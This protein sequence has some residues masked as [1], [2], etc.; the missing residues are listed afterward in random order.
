MLKHRYVN[1]VSAMAKKA[2]KNAKKKAPAKKARKSKK[3]KKGSLLGR[4]VKWLFVLGLWG[5]IALTLMLAWYAQDLPD[6]TQA[7]TFERR[8]SIIIKAADGSVITRYGDMKRT[9][10][11]TSDLPSHLIYAIISTE[12][13]RFYQHYGVDPMGIARAMAVNVQK[14]RL[15]QG[16]STIT[17]QL[18]KNLFLSHERTLKRKI[19][20]AM[21]ALWL[22]HGLTKDEILSAYLNR[23]YLGSGAYGVDAAA[24]LYFGKP[25]SQVN[26]RESAT[27]AGLLKA[28]SRYSPLKNPE[29][30]RTR[31]D[32]V[33]K[34]MV[35][36]G[37]ITQDQ[38]EGMVLI[39]ATPRPQSRSSG[40]TRYYTDWVVDGIDDLIGTPRQDLIVHTTLQPDIQNNVE[41]ALT[42]TLNTYGEER[43][44]SQGAAVILDTNGAVLAMVGGKNYRESQF[45]RITQA[46]RQPGSAFK[47]IL[48]L[49]AL[50]KGWKPDDLILDAPIKKGSY[51]PKN[52][53]HEYLGEITL[54][55]A[56]TRSLNTAA[57]R[58]MKETG[59]GPVIATARRLGIHSKL[60]PDLSL[61]LGSSVVSPLEMSVAY[62]SFANGGHSV[63]P[64]AITRITDDEDNIYYE[65]RRRRGAHRVIEKSHVNDLN[66]MLENVV[67]NGTGRRAKQSFTTAGKTG[68]SQ[69]SRDAWFIGYSD[70][71]I[72][73]VW[74]GNDDNTPME[75]V[76]GG[77]LP[78]QI[79][80]DMMESS[81]GKYKAPKPSLLK[82]S[83]SGIGSLLRKITGGERQPEKDSSNLN[84]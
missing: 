82:S 39:P 57:V 4:M 51:R 20:E 80:H 74:L 13:R 70:K 37:Y 43:T 1:F 73:A 44:V 14:G 12:D 77:N 8:S 22:E 79:W 66:T 53:D 49:T 60:E 84:R 26:L 72:G 78:A 61:A 47:P 11:T 58:L 31:S 17:Q 41:K 34:A 65:R 59:R 81:H 40:Q 71:M 21:L 56:L 10:V 3:K 32:T 24:R 16:G 69:E 33:L 38:A 52:F 63:I 7:P 54:E 19:Q 25:A 48:Y 18:A 83:R 46:R 50:E 15:V 2:K 55:T 27:L 67:E 36:A 62:V 23:V 42:N 64:Y 75:N 6:I 29:L 68:T 45:N 9:S 76:T 35:H 5:G 28:P 30:S